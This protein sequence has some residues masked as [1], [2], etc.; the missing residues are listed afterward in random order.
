M[1][2]SVWPGFSWASFW[3]ASLRSSSYTDGK[4]SLATLNSPW[5]TC[6]S[7]GIMSLIPVR[8]RSAAMMAKSNPLPQYRDFVGDPGL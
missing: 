3:A 4:R 6:S 2:S 5:L 7:V 8:L 1:A